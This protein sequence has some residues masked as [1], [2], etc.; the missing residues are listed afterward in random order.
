MT[1]QPWSAA[2]LASGAVLLVLGSLMLPSGQIADVIHAVEFE[3]AQWVMAS[4]A[5][6]L[7]SVGLTLGLPTVLTLLRRRGRGIG[8]VGV[9]VWSLG[10]IATSGY[11]A[12][13]IFFSALVNAVELTPADVEA[14]ASDTTLV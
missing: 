2:S 11:A 8:L 4:F 3:G 13:L 6:V 9:G 12:M 1:W 7:E 5:L 14:I 10:T